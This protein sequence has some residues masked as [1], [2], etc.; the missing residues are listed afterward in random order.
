MIFSVGTAA[1]ASIVSP[2]AASATTGAAASLR[3]SF[4]SV[5]EIKSSTSTTFGGGGAA[6]SAFF[7]AVLAAGAL[8]P[9]IGVNA[10]FGLLGDAPRGLRDFCSS[11]NDTASTGAAGL[12]VVVA[13][14]SAAFFAWAVD[15]LAGAAGAA[16]V[17]G[18]FAADVGAGAGAGVRLRVADVLLLLVGEVE[19][20][21]WMV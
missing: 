12:A 19:R 21:M 1:G 16:F 18:F 20:G 13:T 2:G 9:E 3:A 5:A 7:G 17:A 4:S 10:A 11:I 14:G 8:I 6:G 15:A